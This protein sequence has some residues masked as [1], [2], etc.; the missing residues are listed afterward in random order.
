MPR[1]SFSSLSFDAQA[2]GNA[3]LDL[4]SD[5]RQCMA[6]LLANLRLGQGIRG[7][8]SLPRQAQIERKKKKEREEEEKGTK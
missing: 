2:S 8:Q 6:G 5:P 7:L 4:W 1:L 3:A